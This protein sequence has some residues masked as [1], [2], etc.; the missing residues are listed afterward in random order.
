MAHELDVRENGEH[1]YIGV[2]DAWHKL[3]TVFEDG[4]TLEQAM[5]FG[6]LNWNVEKVQHYI[7]MKAVD[8][9]TGLQVGARG[10]TRAWNVESPDSF[11]VI[12]DDRQ[13]SDAVIGNVGRIWE[14]LQNR[15]AFGVL[16]PLLDAGMCRLETAGALRNGARVWM[17]IQFDKQKIVA[18]AEDY[19]STRPTVERDEAM[20]QLHDM[21][22]D[23]A[24]FA[25]LTNDHSGQA[26]AKIFECWIRVVCA[27][28]MAAAERKQ[29][30]IS[31]AVSHTKNVTENYKE[32]ATMIF[33]TM[34]SR[35]ADFAGQRDLLMRTPLDS[36]TSYAA[37]PF[38]EL[39]LDVCVPVAHLEQRLLSRVGTMKATETALNKAH[40][41]RDAIKA[42]WTRGDGHTG[43]HSAW[44]AW[45]GVI[46]YFDH[47]AELTKSSSNRLASLQGG[48]LG[49]IKNQVGHNLVQHSN[50]YWSGGRELVS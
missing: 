34:A 18:S 31:L 50:A 4:F 24:P 5:E 44:E 15:D 26:M 21:L 25:L 47:D 14:P 2:K 20:R 40:L 36:D 48:V 46:Q 11:A 45:Q 10:W 30:G 35:Y 8:Q 32:G 37:S 7:R 33:Q 17:Q 19:L 43:N 6:G 27:N 1:S 3:G 41:K 9:P 42:M 22:G 16:E 29:K 38:R 28:T 39:V 23:I 12:R 49:K 13:G